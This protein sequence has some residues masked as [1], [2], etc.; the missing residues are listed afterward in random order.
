MNSLHL[1]VGQLG[2]V[3]NRFIET[4]DFNSLHVPANP[5]PTLALP[6]LPPLATSA[7]QSTLR[8]EGDLAQ[9]RLVTP[10][11]L[12]SCTNLDILSNSVVRIAV[13]AEG[14]PLLPMLLSRSGSSEADQYALERAR[15]A[16]FEPV[17]RNPAETVRNPTADLSWGRMVFRW[18]TVPPPPT[19]TP[20][21]SP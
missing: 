12:R 3:F 5:M 20:A 6:S 4:N 19:N 1:A 14:R 18:H 11:P 21:A 15:A 8:L 7:E 2:T 17:R 10:L 9:R 16:R 13:D